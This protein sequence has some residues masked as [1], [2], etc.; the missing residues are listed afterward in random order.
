MV[1]RICIFLCFL[2][3]LIGWRGDVSYAEIP[4][5]LYTVQ[6]GDTLYSIGLR[7]GIPLAKLIAYNGTLA[8]PNVI[9]P[10]VTLAVPHPPPA[11]V[12]GKFPLPK[13]TYTYTNDYKTPREV[14]ADGTVLRVHEGVDLF[15][16]EGTPIYAVYGGTVFNVGWNNSGGWRL[17]V[18]TAQN[19]V[20]YYAHLSRYARPFFIGERI[21]ANELIGYVGST[22][23]G[24]VGTTGKFPPHLHF[25]MYTVSPWIA[26][27]PYPYL[28][29]WEL[30]S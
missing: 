4:S 14:G 21:V 27:T 1:K 24:P 11:Y 28:E 2:T 22:G 10:G 8:N 20:M 26:V 12:T 25:G 17:T 7:F 23:Y 30:G 5:S 16:R 13:L 18:R 3:G 9:W 6:S 15:A 29:W 19:T